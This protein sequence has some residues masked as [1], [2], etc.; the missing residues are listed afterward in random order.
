[1]VI[2]IAREVKL[3][4]SV[5]SMVGVDLSIMCIPSAFHPKAITVASS[6]GSLACGSLPHSAF[7]ERPETPVAYREKLAAHS[8]GGSRGFRKSLTA[9]PIIP[10]GGRN[11]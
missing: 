5:S 4:S 3:V 10:P 1:M 11:R 8:C 6:A 2:W 7:P 9:F